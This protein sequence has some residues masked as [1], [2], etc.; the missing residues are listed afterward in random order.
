MNNPIPAPPRP[1]VYQPTT[2]GLDAGRYD[3]SYPGREFRD[4]LVALAVFPDLPV[5]ASSPHWE[6]RVRAEVLRQRLRVTLPDQFPC[7]YET[8]DSPNQRRHPNPQPH[9]WV[10]SPDL[11]MLTALLPDYQDLWDSYTSQWGDDSRRTFAVGRLD[12]LKPHGVYRPGTTPEQVIGST[13][14]THERMYHRAP[15][16]L[17][18]MHP[19]HA[20]WE[21]DRAAQAARSAS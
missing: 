18:A 9:P 3:V 13:M 10:I 14:L 17:R 11:D 19:R 7:I 4:D 21:A 2:A 5:L 20:D 8:A 15:E 1:L 16:R 12:G 6:D